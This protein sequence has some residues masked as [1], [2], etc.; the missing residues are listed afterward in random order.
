[1]AEPEVVDLDLTIDDLVPKSPERIAEEKKESG[2]H[3]YKFKNYTGALA[4]YEEAIKL[5]PENASY[6]G[7]RSACDLT[8]GEQAVKKAAEL[9]GADCASNEK[10]AL[11][12]LRKL[13][14]DAQKALESGDYRRVV[15]CNE[16]FKMGRWQ[17]ALNLYNEALKIDKTNRKVNAKLYFNKAT[18]CAKLNQTQ[19]AA[20]ACTAALE[21]DENYVKAILRR[22]KCYT[23]LDIDPNVVFQSFFRGSG[24]DFQG[25]PYTGNV[26][27]FQFG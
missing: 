8:G 19:E 21:L 12:S 16:A 18:V 3:L 24:F 7:N 15:F 6:Y 1:M 9:G 27:N 22:A 17:Q 5:C 20:N 23:E 10:R 26:F 4:M 14:D 11:E 25:T 2:N 13:H